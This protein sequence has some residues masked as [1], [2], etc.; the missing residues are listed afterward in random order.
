MPIPTALLRETVTVEPY[1]GTTGQG[2]PTY[3]E[4]LTYRARILGKRRAARTKD[5]TDVISDAVAVIRPSGREFPPESRLTRADGRIYE[6][7][8]VAASEDLHSTHNE[9]LI[10]QGP[11]QEQTP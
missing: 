5:G 1:E 7:L 6:V 2:E 9:E 4:P 10:L 11:R 8:G 3:G